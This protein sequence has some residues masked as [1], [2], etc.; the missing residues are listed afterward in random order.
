MKYTVKLIDYGNILNLENYII[1][2]CN[3]VVN[4]NGNYYNPQFQ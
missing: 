2:Q 3:S 1:P 4:L